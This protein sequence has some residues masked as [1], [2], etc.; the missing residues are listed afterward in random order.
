ME[1]VLKPLQPFLTNL[2][3]KLSQFPLAVE[4][5]TRTKVPK[6]IAVLAV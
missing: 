4:F 3:S 1:K 2:D 5:E 6:S